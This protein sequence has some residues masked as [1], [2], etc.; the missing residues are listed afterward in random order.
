MIGISLGDITGIGPEVTLKALA[1]ELAADD[2]RY[3]IIG[4]VEH[5][6]NLNQRLRLNLPFGTG[7][8]NHSRV[9]IFN[10]LSKALASKLAP[11]AAE[12]A[13]AAVAWLK[14]AAA[15][16]LRCELDG[17]VTAPVNKESIIRSGHE[18]VGQTELLSELAG[19]DR[20]AM[21]LLGHD[22]R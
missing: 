4:D 15:R 17:M 3:L 20:T 19:T 14:E 11:G 7:V 5:V 21:M 1:A 9:T 8:K 13:Q 16:C 12:A 18:F 6:Q 2:A 22:D 10:P